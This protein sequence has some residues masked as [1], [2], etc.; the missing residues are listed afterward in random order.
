MTRVPT[1]SA[2]VLRVDYE[3]PMGHTFVFTWHLGDEAKLV[4]HIMR[5]IKD[6]DILFD[7]HDALDVTSLARKQCRRW[8]CG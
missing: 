6:E 5:L 7:A 4:R 3:N 8:T 2:P 1:V